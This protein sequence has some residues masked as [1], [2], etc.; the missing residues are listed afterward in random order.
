[1]SYNVFGELIRGIREKENLSQVQIGKMAGVYKQIITMT[2]SGERIPSKNNYTKIVDAFGLDHADLAELY[3]DKI[4]DV[5]NELDS[6]ELLTVIRK[7]SLQIR[8]R[9]D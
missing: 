9:C 4:V 1:M 3:I 5:V 2:E 7:L 6:Y 8:R